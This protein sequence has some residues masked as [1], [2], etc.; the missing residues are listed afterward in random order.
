MTSMSILKELKKEANPV[1]AK[2]S[3]RFF[4]TGPG[5][6]SEGDIFL[7]LS[8]PQTMAIAKKNKDATLD[9]LEELLDS[10]LHEARLCA[11]FILVNQYKKADDVQKKKLMKFYLKK[12]NR[13]NNWDLVDCSA[14]RILGQYCFDNE[15]TTAMKKL[16]HSKNL[17]DRRIAMLSTFPFIRNNKTELAF[18]YAQVLLT[19]EEDLMHKAV[20]W[21]LRETC[22]HNE[23]PLLQFIDKH[24]KKMPRT[25]LRY[26]IEKFPPKTRKEI[27]LK[28]RV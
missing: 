4:K 17:W 8:N 5:Q 10:P 26:A 27:L 13:I 24:G 21:M 14:P 9:D 7:G 18:Q 2:H 6:Y 23:K 16:L 3:Q 28:T 1:R 19:D 22:K 15:D 12:K 11:L 20:G 25:M